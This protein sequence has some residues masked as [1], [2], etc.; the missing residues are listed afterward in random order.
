MQE[1]FGVP[2]PPLNRHNLAACATSLSKRISELAE[3]DVN[4]EF[5]AEPLLKSVEMVQTQIVPNLWN[6]NG[7]NAYQAY[8]ATLGWIE[9]LFQ[10]VF[11]SRTDWQ[12]VANSGQLPKSLAKRLRALQSILDG[13][14][15][16]ASEVGDKMAYIQQAHDA[17]LALPTDLESLREAA[18]EVDAYKATAE[19]GASATLTS[20]DAAQNSLASITNKD[21]EAAKLIENIEDAYSAATTKGLGEAFQQRADRLAKSMW[22]WVAGLIIALVI[23]AWLG[24]SRVS[25]LQELIIKGGAT[26]LVWLNM[27]I[28]FFSI[29]APVWFAWIATKQIGHRFRLSEDYAFKATVA[30][31]YAGYQREAA[32]LDPAFAARLFSSALNRIE[33]APIR[34]VESETYGSPWHEA[35]RLRTQRRGREAVQR[36]EKL[37]EE[38]LVGESGEEDRTA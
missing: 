35:F 21:A 18:K 4:P 34:F 33:E 12:T 10:P 5:S 13:L 29:A 6:G 14:D 26:G 23:G 27:L 17:A 2:Y 9:A 22:T 7:L 1:Q 19:R 38:Q 3:G 11:K 15:E 24:S 28:A 20:F 8:L 32:R 16:D 37:A 36:E 30:R 31:A 25:L